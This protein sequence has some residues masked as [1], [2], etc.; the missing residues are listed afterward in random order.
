MIDYEINH[1]T[2]LRAY[3]L[4][5][6]DSKKTKLFFKDKRIP[7]SEKKILHSLIDLRKNNFDQ[8][9]ERLLSIRSINPF[10]NGFKYFLLG[11]F[12]YG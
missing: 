8:G 7:Q 12:F 3:E 10:V 1:K 5:R 9:V 6:V 4:L 11:A 2:F